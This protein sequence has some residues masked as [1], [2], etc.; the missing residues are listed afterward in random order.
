MH[1]S[2]S[3]ESCFLRFHCSLSMFVILFV[4]LLPASCG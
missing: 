1:F 4:Q 3:S 2:H